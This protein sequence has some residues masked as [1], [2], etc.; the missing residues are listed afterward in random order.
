MRELEIAVIVPDRGV[1]EAYDIL[2]DFKR[3][4]DYSPEVR[5]VIIESNN[6]EQFSTWETTFRGGL[7]RWKER[8]TFDPVTNTIGFLQTEG[9][10]EHFAGW[11]KIAGENGGSKVRFWAE[12]DM[13]I[14]SLS[15]IIDPIAEQALRENIIAILQGLFGPKVELLPEAGLVGEKSYS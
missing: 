7:L 9:D 12:F 3:Y 2:C 6:G 14:P 13:G 8:D 10:I 11:W 4:P 1:K 5:S 15:A